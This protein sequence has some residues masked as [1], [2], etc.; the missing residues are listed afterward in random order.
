MLLVCNYPLCSSC[1]IPGKIREITAKI[2]EQLPEIVDMKARR[3]MW[4]QCYEEMKEK[5]GKEGKEEC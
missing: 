4:D 3:D 2:N 5:V 1:Q